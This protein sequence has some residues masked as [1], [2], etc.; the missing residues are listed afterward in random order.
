MGGM[1]SHD[2]VLLATAVVHHMHFAITYY[3][4]PFTSAFVFK[5]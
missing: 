3:V 4:D 2:H 5:R 1:A